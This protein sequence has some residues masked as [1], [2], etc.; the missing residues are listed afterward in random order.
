[1]R[2]FEMETLGGTADGG[3][4]GIVD[5]NGWLYCQGCDFIFV[6]PG[7]HPGTLKQRARFRRVHFSTRAI[8]EAAMEGEHEGAVEQEAPAVPDPPAPSDQGDGAGSSEE[9]SADDGA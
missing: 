1:M 7:Q 9:K 4:H 5:V 8:K 2:I 3:M 6:A